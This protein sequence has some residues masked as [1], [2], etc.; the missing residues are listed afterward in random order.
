M[1]N[2]PRATFWNVQQQSAASES[3]QF[4]NSG[5]II[6]D[7]LKPTPDYLGDNKLVGRDVNLML[8]LFYPDRYGIEEY[9]GWDLT[10][11]GR[12][13]REL[14]ILLNRDGIG[15][16]SLQLYFNGASNYFRELPTEPNR[17]IYNQID[18]WNN[19]TI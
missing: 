11:I 19:I 15:S 10:R 3:Q 17:E 6:V 5:N 18:E 7:K 4:T 13:H 2:S 9:E 12:N 8:G 1:V 16:A 14:L